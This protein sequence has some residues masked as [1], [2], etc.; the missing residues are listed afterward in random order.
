MKGEEC[1]S[2]LQSVF[3]DAA[4]DLPCPLL[5]VQGAFGYVSTQWWERATRKSFAEKNRSGRCASAFVKSRVL[6][7]Q[8]RKDGE[9]KEVQKFR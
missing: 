9:E 7:L 5:P 4:T 8:W 3:S 1:P 2:S 6:E